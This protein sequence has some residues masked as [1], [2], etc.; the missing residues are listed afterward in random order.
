MESL[1]DILQKMGAPTKEELALVEKAYN[2]AAEA[3]K[4]HKRFSGEPYLN[5]LVETAKGL[6]GL[7]MGAKTV[8]AGLL[9]DS[10]EDAGVAP[11]TLEREFGKEIRFLVEGVTKLG[12]LKY[13][14][15]E[16]H[17]ESL[18]KLLVATGKDARVLII[19]L[20]DRLHNMRTL[21]WVPE[22]K[23]KRIALETLEIYA[24]IAHRLG[25]GVVRRQL[26]DLAFEHAFPAEYA[27]TKKLLA[28]KSKETFDRLE[29]MSRTLRKELAKE[30]MKGFRSDHR[31]KGLYSL[32][33]KLERK[34]GDIEKIYDIAALRVIVAD[35][36]DCYRALGIVNN[37]WQP[38]PNKIKDYIAFPKPNGYQ[39]LHTTV[40][41]GDG[42]IVEV[43][44]R[45]EEM[46]R[47]A[48]YGITAAHVSYKEG[49]S[50][51]APG[52]RAGGQRQSSFDW[53]K[54]LI[55]S[56]R[57]GADKGGESSKEEK[58]ETRRARYGAQG[59]PEWL[60]DLAEEAETE[61]FETTLRT[62]IFTQR[63]FVFTPT[64]DVVDLPANSSSIDFAYAIHSDIGDH[65]AGAKVNGKLV[66]LDTPLH[67]GDIV[68]IST[69]KTAT[70]KQKWLDF[71][72]TTLA[73]RHIR[74][75]LEK[76]QKN[77][78]PAAKH[79]KS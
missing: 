12:R 2:F 22:E 62:D 39:S 15:A 45:T 47:E 70:P 40:F 3:H 59:G 36:P 11:E 9:H 37:L 1:K 19:K 41:S 79:K 48:E 71:A 14:G 31:V 4:D 58:E 27:E 23:R 75:A 16:R 13:R 30:G 63:V 26:E 57:R 68:E 69:K 60:E 65:V 38:L 53:I 76:E 28:E 5:H 35:V 24:A 49:E 25:M 10:I 72:K 67:N 44:I 50:P 64:G 32:W 52:A 56:F 7:G 33:R 55:P 21:K 73:R 43:Q 34:G 46:H 77:N 17:R 42:G 20:M 78:L 51:D 66:P 29:K 18:R 74:M 54:S 8:A 61:D 6:A